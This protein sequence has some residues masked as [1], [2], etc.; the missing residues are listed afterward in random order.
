MLSAA[1]H[2]TGCDEPPTKLS[3]PT[4]AVTATTGAVWSAIVKSELLAT[5]VALPAAS[6]A[7]TRTRASVET[8]FGTLQPTLP[9]LAIAVAIVLHVPP[10]SSE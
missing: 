4:G 3:P 10:S 1:V 8:A 7:V 2:V 9:L 6:R 5:A